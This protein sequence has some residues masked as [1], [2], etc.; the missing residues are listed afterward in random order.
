ML[1]AL[2][3]RRW[4]ARSRERLARRTGAALIPIKPLL[5]DGSSRIAATTT[6]GGDATMT[7]IFPDG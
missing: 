6:A 1:T 3:R 2:A 7:M 5:N 4:G